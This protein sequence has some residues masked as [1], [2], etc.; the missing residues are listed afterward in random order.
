MTQI[1]TKLTRFKDASW[2]GQEENVI[3]GGAGGISS[4]LTLMLA[5]ANFMPVVYDFDTLEEHNL[6]GQLF[7]FSGIGKSKVDVLAEMVFKFTEMDISVMNERYTDQSMTGPFVFAGFDNM[8][9]RNDMYQLWKQ[10]ALKADTPEIA[11]AYIFIDG[12]LLAEQMQVFCI[13]GDNQTGMAD[14]EANHLFLDSDVP[15]GPCTFKQTSHA[16]AMIAAFMCGFFTNHVHN[17]RTAT[18]QRFVPFYHEYYI[19]LNLMS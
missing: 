16:A 8:L 11:S 1:A 17:M 14:Y 3:V 4:W 7:P 13:T 18:K 6:G 2:L 9:A 12:R 10:N 5:R 19:P 15:D